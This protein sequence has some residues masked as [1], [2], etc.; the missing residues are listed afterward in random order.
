MKLLKT[1]WIPLVLAI[2]CPQTRAAV[3]LANADISTGD[4]EQ[5]CFA[6]VLLGDD[7]FFV[8]KGEQHPQLVLP[9]GPAD[10]ENVRRMRAKFAFKP[11]P[12]EL[13]T[14]DCLANCETVVAL[15][16]IELTVRRD[17]EGYIQAT[18]ARALRAGRAGR[19]YQAPKTLPLDA[20]LRGQDASPPAKD[21]ASCTGG[22]G[23]GPGD[24]ECR[25]TII[26]EVLTCICTV[27]EVVWI[28]VT[29]TVDCL[30]NI[31]DAESFEHRLPIRLKGC[32][33]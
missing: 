19:G 30:G 5:H 18:W 10:G 22:G 33:C 21:A 15:A 26:Y 28:G 1:L 16:N 25:N 27:T 20:I 29:K 6:W 3:P 23:T 8:W 24:V 32:L 7:M 2:V 31:L 9:L 11:V 12:G 14:G 4:C 17:G 13:Y